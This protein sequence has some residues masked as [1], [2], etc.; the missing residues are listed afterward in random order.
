MVSV[1]Q[2][3]RNSL[4]IW[5]SLANTNGREG[6]LET[7]KRGNYET[8]KRGNYETDERGVICD[9]W[10]LQAVQSRAATSPARM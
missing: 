6:D 10:F 4:Y 2:S 7:D 1:I 8:D 5:T 9:L 3:C